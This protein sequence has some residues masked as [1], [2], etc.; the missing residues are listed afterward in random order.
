[1]IYGGLF[2][3]DKKIERLDEINK[4]M[5]ESDFW[6]KSLKDD[7]LKENSYLSNLVNKLTLFCHIVASNVPFG[8]LN[9]IV[10]LVINLSGLT[11]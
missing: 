9:S 2:D 7:I 3:L 5:N 6:N 10:L 8:H 11:T 1:M 4:I